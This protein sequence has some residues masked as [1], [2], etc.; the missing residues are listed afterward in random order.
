MCTLFANTMAVKAM[1]RLFDARERMV[2][3]RTMLLAAN[4][5]LIVQTTVGTT[6]VVIV[7]AQL[8]GFLS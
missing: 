1:R 5:L 6:S 4:Y 2:E 8:T 3:S 7:L